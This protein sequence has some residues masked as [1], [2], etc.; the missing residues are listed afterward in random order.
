MAKRKSTKK[1]A[2]AQK[3][4]C[5]SWTPKQYFSVLLSEAACYFFL[6]FLLAYL[7]VLGAWVPALVLLILGNLAVWFCPCSK[8]C[9]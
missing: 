2:P 4:C 5:M 3:T 6:Y 1:V 7:G 8:V 9:R